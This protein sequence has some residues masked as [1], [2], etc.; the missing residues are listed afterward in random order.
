MPDCHGGFRGSR[1]AQILPY[2]P[3][4]APNLNELCGVTLIDLLS[5]I[6]C[7]AAPRSSLGGAVGGV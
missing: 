1:S 3:Q 5:L 2:P 7:G 6:A 4:V